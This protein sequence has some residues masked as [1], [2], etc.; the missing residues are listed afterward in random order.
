M[1]R[2]AMTNKQGH[3]SCP[4][5]NAGRRVWNGRRAG[6]EDGRRKGNKGVF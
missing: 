6:K 1:K 2:G 5:G 3:A 4:I